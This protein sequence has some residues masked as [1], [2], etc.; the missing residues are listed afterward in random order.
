[1]F[2]DVCRKQ[3]VVEFPYKGYSLVYKEWL[4]GYIACQDS[5]RTTIQKLRNNEKLVQA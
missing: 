3:G 2:K 4:N 5:R 1:M